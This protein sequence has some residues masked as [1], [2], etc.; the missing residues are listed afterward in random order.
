MP[1]IGC[2]NRDTCVELLPSSCIPYVGYI[3]TT[4]AANVQ[5]RPNIN[6]VMKA[7]QDLMDSIKISLGD[8]T[9]LTPGCFDFDPAT[10]Q[11]SALNQN[12]ITDICAL[13]TA[14]D[15][16][17][18]V[19]PNTLMLTVDLLCLQDPSCSPQPSYSLQTIIVKLLTAY[20]N[21]A[22]RVTTIE[23]FLNL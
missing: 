12:F 9:T 16:I 10:V 20:C 17:P 6:D 11:Q 13:Q 8:N 22:T 5:C 1:C 19:D 23:N 15:N 2:D 7:I 18:A 21:L 14:V 4:I 3:S